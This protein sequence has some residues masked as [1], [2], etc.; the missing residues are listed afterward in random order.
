MAN[1]STSDAASHTGAAIPPSYAK[2]HL[3]NSALLLPNPT[4][5]PR[6]IKYMHVPRCSSVHPA[7]K[8]NRNG[9]DRTKAP[10]HSSTISEFLR[11]SRCV[12]PGTSCNITLNAPFQ[13][14]PL[15]SSPAI[16]PPFDTDSLDFLRWLH[17]LPFDDSAPYQEPEQKANGLTTWPNH[18]LRKIRDGT[19]NAHQTKSPNPPE[20]PGKTKGPKAHERALC[21]HIIDLMMPN[22]GNQ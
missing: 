6:Q 13:T 5:P 1:N 17:F 2:R 19:P 20:S 22:H 15:P 18:K 9:N 14:Y 4:P 8:C 11:P 10:V 12:T 16:H 3:H 7:P 21:P